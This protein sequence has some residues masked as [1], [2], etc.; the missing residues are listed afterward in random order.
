LNFIID[1]IDRYDISSKFHCFVGDNAS[2]NDGELIK[3]LTSI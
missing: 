1:I 2:S 3:G